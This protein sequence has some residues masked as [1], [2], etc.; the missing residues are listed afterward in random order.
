MPIGRVCRYWGSRPRFPR[1][2]SVVA[3]SRKLIPSPN[4]MPRTLEVAIRE[5]VGKRGVSVVAIPGD[6]ALLPADD[7][8]VAAPASLLPPSPQVRPAPRE[9]EQL[10]ALLNGGTRVTVF[11]GSGCEGAHDLL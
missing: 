5:A 1:P 3:I 2:R 10:A 4:Q 7:A 8:P 6:I 9:L 11:C